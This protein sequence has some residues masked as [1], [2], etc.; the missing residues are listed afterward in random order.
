[1]K[2]LVQVLVALVLAAAQAALLRWVGGGVFSVSLL[3]ACVVHL[4]LSEGNVD[5]SVAA[6]GTGYVLDVVTGAPKG[7][8][9]FLCVLLFVLV[10][11]VGA[12][13]DVRGRAPFALLSGLG[14]AVLSVGALLL[15]RFTSSPEAAP[16]VNLAG[17][18]LVEALATAAVAPVVLALLR[19]VDLLF[20]REEPGLL[21]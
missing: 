6:A 13:V 20:D 11:G 17:R 16:G 1:V 18:I 15:T 4:G 19:R 21:P 5:G 2:A 12:A 7:L 14:A 3:A 9:T 8:H 10:R